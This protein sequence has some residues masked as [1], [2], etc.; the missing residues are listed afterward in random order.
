[1]RPACPGMMMEVSETGR[2]LSWD[3]VAALLGPARNYWLGTVNLD[4]TPHAAPVW[5]V[6]V[7]SVVFLYTE[8]STRKAKNLARDGRGV[9]H[10]ESAEEVVI[11][12]GDFEDAGHPRGLTTVLGALAAK[13]DRPEDR[14]YLPSENEE[15]DVV[16]RL[17]P[18]RALLWQLSDYDASQ[19]RWDAPPGS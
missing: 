4:G 12:H 13:Y 8:R 18:R 14:Q 3:E 6:V 9:L 17:R 16:H 15:F 5:G 19:A 11:V 2:Q 1:M 7:D 10:L